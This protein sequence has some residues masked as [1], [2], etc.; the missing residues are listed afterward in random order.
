VTAPHS[1]GE[2][3][4]ALR[5]E[6]GLVAQAAT[7][8]GMTREG[9]Y[10]R[11]KRSPGL[12]AALAEARAA[13]TDVAESAL[14]AAIRDREAWAV[15]FYLKTQGRDRGYIERQEVQHDGTIG[16]VAVRELVVELPGEN[17]ALAQGS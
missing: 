6:H 13:M 14:F 11:I 4:A 10:K 12:Q 1:H 7:R 16:F 3:A 15:C 17:G 9:L 8:L 5:A 2:L